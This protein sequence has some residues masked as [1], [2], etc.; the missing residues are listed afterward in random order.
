MLKKLSFSVDL[1]R[2]ACSQELPG[3]KQISLFWQILPPFQSEVRKTP[4]DLL[5]DTGINNLQYIPSTL[6]DARLALE[7]QLTHL[8]LACKESPLPHPSCALKLFSHR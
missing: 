5:K 8:S 3:T 7:Q 1:S 2:Y 4:N 6:I